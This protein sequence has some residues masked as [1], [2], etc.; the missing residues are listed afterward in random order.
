MSKLSKITHAV[1]SKERFEAN[2]FLWS[3]VKSFFMY[4]ESTYKALSVKKVLE[5]FT[6]V[7]ESYQESV[8]DDF[9]FS[10]TNEETMRE[11]AINDV[12]KRHSE[13]LQIFRHECAIR[14]TGRY[15]PEDLS[16]S[17]GFVLGDFYYEDREIYG[18]VDLI[19]IF[20][21]KPKYELIYDYNRI[22]KRSSYYFY[23]V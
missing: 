1:S 22:T 5:V 21:I 4:D 11:Q 16:I 20:I 15:K 23:I 7:F 10:S 9:Y 8:M 14:P 2:S 13:I 18:K 12:K 19:H 3:I 6:D 17:K